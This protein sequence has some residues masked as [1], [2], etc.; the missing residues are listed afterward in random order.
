MVY[1]WSKVTRDRLTDRAASVWRPRGEARRTAGPIASQAA[2]RSAASPDD[3]AASAEP[4]WQIAETPIRAADAEATS[5][6][7]RSSLAVW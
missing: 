3:I 1:G 2:E 5:P 6:A 4:C 7:A